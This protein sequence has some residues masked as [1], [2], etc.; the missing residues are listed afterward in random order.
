VCQVP[1]NIF[2]QQGVK[3][4]SSFKDRN[5][6][7]KPWRFHNTEKYET[8]DRS[9]TNWQKGSEGN[10]TQSHPEP[11][12]RMSGAI[13]LFPLH[14]FMW[15]GTILQFFFRERLP[16]FPELHWKRQLVQTSLHSA[17]TW[18]WCTDT[19]LRTWVASTQTHTYLRSVT[20]T[21][22]RF[23]I[24]EITWHKKIL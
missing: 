6:W 15:T 24:L 7:I 8:R 1:S 4:T 9:N 5:L 10:L 14:A 2:F 16:L 17:G 18:I 11:R 21:Q 13:P 19:L 3:V 22:K 20:F 12:L 23:S